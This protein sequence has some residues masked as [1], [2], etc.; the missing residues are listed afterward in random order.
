[1]MKNKRYLRYKLALAGG[2][3]CLGLSGCKAPYMAHSEKMEFPEH[4]KEV[5]PSKLTLPH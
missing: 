5:I 1:M 3:I 2:I 4:M